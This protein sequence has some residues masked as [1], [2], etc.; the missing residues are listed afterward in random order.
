MMHLF[1]QN[2]SQDLKLFC[3]KQHTIEITSTKF[4]AMLLFGQLQKPYLGLQK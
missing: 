2:I 1:Q 3:S 4:Q